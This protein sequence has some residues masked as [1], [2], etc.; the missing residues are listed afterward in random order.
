MPRWEAV[1]ADH[2]NSLQVT[3]LYY[4]FSLLSHS[5]LSL[6][7]PS[8]VSPFMCPSF[9][10]PL[11]LYLLPSSLFYRPLCSLVFPSS[12]FSP[13]SSPLLSCSSPSFLASPPPPPLPP[14]FLLLPPPSFAPSFLTS[15]PLPPP[16]DTELWSYLWSRTSFH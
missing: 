6:P 15:P 12:C 16:K 8:C 3:R 13:S 14:P 1:P 11:F 2:S 5:L 4:H 9:F 7:P 10:P